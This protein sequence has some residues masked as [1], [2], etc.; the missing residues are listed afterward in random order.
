[1][2]RTVWRQQATVW[3]SLATSMIV[4]VL[5]WLSGRKWLIAISR[6]EAWLVAIRR[7]WARGVTLSLFVGL[8]IVGE[9]GSFGNR[10]LQLK[11]VA[12]T[13]DSF[14]NRVV[15]NFYMALRHAVRDHRQLRDV[16]SRPAKTFAGGIKEAARLI[17]P[18]ANNWTTLD[19]CSR[20]EAIGA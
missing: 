7:P 13:T 14:L 12:V 6:L 20:R 11:D 9:R 3:F 4:V 16:R 5:C 8:A 18:D 15:M 10:P 2:L 17:F 1:I 19:E